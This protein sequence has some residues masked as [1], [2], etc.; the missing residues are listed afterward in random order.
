M[1]KAIV[2]WAWNTL[3][4]KIEDT[5]ENAWRGGSSGEAGGI[6]EYLDA[7]SSG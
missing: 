3:K 2:R 5:A 4:Q 6:D 7:V 1:R